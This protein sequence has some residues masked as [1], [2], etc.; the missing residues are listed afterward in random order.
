MDN[1]LAGAI[2]TTIGGIVI[3]C[4]ACYR[5]QNTQ[6]IT[7]T[8]ASTPTQAAN[9]TADPPPTS[10]PVAVAAP[11]S[12]SV[13]LPPAAAENFVMNYG[14]SKPSTINGPWPVNCKEVRVQH[15]VRTHNEA[16]KIAKEQISRDPK[17]HIIEVV[18]L[19]VAPASWTYTVKT[20]HTKDNE[21]SDVHIGSGRRFVAWD[22]SV[23]KHKEKVMRT[24]RDN[25]FF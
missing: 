13:S 15:N 9:P 2:I 23:F 5:R 16:V 20:F 8:C 19:F 6:S 24:L 25:D 10:E 1:E 7:A 14:Q 17:N 22:M 4:I 3:A 21:V 18:E 12:V 11:T